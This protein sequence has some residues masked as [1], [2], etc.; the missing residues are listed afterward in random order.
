MRWHV[1]EAVVRKYEHPHNCV[2]RPNEYRVRVLG[3]RFPISGDPF[4]GFSIRTTPSGYYS[5]ANAN[6]FG[7][8]AKGQT[9]YA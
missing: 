3:Q 6:A 7:I 2:P 8:V 9:I 5:N 1:F 4:E